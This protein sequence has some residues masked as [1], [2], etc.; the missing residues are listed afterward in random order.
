MLLK[1][2]LRLTLGS[3]DI[4]ADVV[5]ELIDIE[6]NNEGD[7]ASTLRFIVRSS[8][9][10]F[11]SDW[12]PKPLQYIK[13]EFFY[14]G[15]TTKLNAGNFQVESVTEKV[16]NNDYD[17]IEIRAISVPIIGRIFEK[18]NLS[19]NNVTL[20]T[21]LKDKALGLGLSAKVQVP[22]LFINAQQAEQSDLEFIRGLAGIWGFSFTIDNGMLVAAGDAY[23]RT[24]APILTMG[25]S[26]YRTLNLEHSGYNTYSDCE[27]SYTWLG[28]EKQAIVKDWAVFTDNLVSLRSSRRLNHAMKFPVVSPY[29]AAY[30]ALEKLIRT[31]NGQVTGKLT[32]IGRPE[33]VALNN[34]QLVGN[35]FNGKYQIQSAVHRFNNSE[36]WRC[37]CKVRGL[38][39]RAG[40]V[41]FTWYD[42]IE[43]ARGS[44][45]GF[46]IDIPGIPGI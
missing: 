24:L 19:F 12:I 40:S 9:N 46:G 8:P 15:S 44:I 45:S 43:I 17:T 7:Q 3:V 30:A 22:E 2:N 35:R 21:I 28:E 16:G 41:Q 32:S 37:E 42:M 34:V 1:P 13:C 11:N 10:I 25:R 20:E 29:H 39:L 27:V 38:P 4:S 6:Y 14:E 5:P 18:R 33:L 31:N 26:E 23:F 36:G